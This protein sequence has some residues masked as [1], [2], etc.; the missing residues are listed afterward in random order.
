M[1]REDELPFA[2]PSR[3]STC[4]V[5]CRN[6]FRVNRTGQRS[7]GPVGLRVGNRRFS[8][9]EP[10]A[11]PTRKNKPHTCDAFF[12]RAREERS[13][14]PGGSWQ[15]LHHASHLRFDCSKHRAYS[16]RYSKQSRI[17]EGIKVS[18]RRAIF[19]I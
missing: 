13:K 18:I 3:S 11:L 9:K 5:S 19:K 12:G 8:S 2:F 10:H 4:V 14:T 15:T 16:K 17:A 1:D 6:V 7:N